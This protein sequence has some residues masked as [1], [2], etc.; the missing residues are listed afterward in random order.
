MAEYP[1]PQG[2]FHNS[3]GGFACQSCGAAL[4]PAD[5]DPKGAAVIH[6]IGMESLSPWNRF[7]LVHEIVVRQFCCPGCAHS[8]AV[9]VRKS[10]DDILLDTRLVVADR[11]SGT[12]DRHAHGPSVR[13]AVR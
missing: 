12:A 11:P 9:E 13:D 5:R 4:C 8:L 3:F 6:E 2:C 7:G 1:P 10:D